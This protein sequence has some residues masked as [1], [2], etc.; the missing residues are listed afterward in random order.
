MRF[1]NYSAGII[2]VPFQ[3]WTP[4]KKDGQITLS[5]RIEPD[6]LTHDFD[7]EDPIVQLMLKAHPE[8]RPVVVKTA[9]EKILAGIL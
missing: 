7:P 8:L 4:P 1:K 6:E 2:S 5:L 9:W 3:V